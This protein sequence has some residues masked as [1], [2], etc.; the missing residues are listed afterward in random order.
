[1]TAEIDDGDPLAYHPAAPGTTEAGWQALAH[2]YHVYF[3]G[4][5]L[6][7][8]LKLG[9]AMAGEWSFRFFRRQHQQKFLSSFD[10]LG[11]SGLP[12]AVAAARYH[13]LSNRIG[14]VEVEYMYESDRKA[15]IRFPHPRWVFDGTALCG[16]P[17]EVGHGFIN[18][19]YGH[20]G[21]TLNNPRLGWVCTSQDATAE[22]GYT[23]YFHEYDR[24]LAPDERVRFVS[25]E[26]PPPF[27]PATAPKVDVSVWTP[28]R[29]QKARR[30][31]AMD[32]VKW[33]VVELV[34][35][36]GAE[37]A[38]TVAVHTAALIGRQFYRDLQARLGCARD[39]DST[40]AF[41]RF[42]ALIAEAHGDAPMRD[43]DT[44]GQRGWRL[45]RG[46]ESLDAATVAVLFDAW[47]ELWHGCLS[48]H[49]RFRAWRVTARPTGADD[50]VGW[51]ITPATGR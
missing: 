20:N 36:V 23:G 34:D 32:Y 44:L 6:Q 26:A 43:G 12:D 25:G 4:L 31:Y 7:V 27:D 9:A 45:V 37:A 30:N 40:D 3:T 46:M 41:C 21:V 19:W 49:D 18:G 15:W 2:L 39:D 17:V 13:Y 5:I 29:L 14:G 8:T 24:D 10:K 16:V 28:E 50:A 1:M 42:M 51:Q 33:G 11:A 22:I 38:R 48:V 47:N 35:L